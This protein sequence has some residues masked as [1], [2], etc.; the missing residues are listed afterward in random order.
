MAPHLGLVAQAPHRV[1]ED[2]DMKSGVEL[3]VMPPRGPSRW[4]CGSS[5][6]IGGAAGIGELGELVVQRLGDRH[7][8]LAAVL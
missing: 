6:W 1:V 4:T 5:I 3:V 7:D 8:A 2:V